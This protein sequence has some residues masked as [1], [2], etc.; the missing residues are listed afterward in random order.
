MGAAATGDEMWHLSC[1]GREYTADNKEQDFL[2]ALYFCNNL[3]LDLMH[4]ETVDQFD[5][6]LWISSTGLL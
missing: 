5:D 2:G 6:A 1:D 3:G 4:W